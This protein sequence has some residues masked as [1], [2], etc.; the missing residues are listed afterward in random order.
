MGLVFLRFTN[1]GVGQDEIID[2]SRIMQYKVNIKC[3]KIIIFFGKSC[4]MI[5][6][7][8]RDSW[9]FKG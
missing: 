9:E 3:L 7:N 4:F 6:F 5:K 1:S 8:G 2:T